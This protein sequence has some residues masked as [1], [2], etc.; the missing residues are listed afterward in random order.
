M[1]KHNVDFEEGMSFL[2]RLTKKESN[3]AKELPLNNKS[4]AES[5]FFANGLN[6]KDKRRKSLHYIIVSQMWLITA[7]VSG[8]VIL[9]LLNILGFI[10]NDKFS[11]LNEIVLSLF[12]F[13]IGLMSEPHIDKVKKF[14]N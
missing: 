12:F 4:Q 9:W 2:T 5:D 1:A 3:K 14:I 11:V 13:V 6:L 8:L 7:I 10:E